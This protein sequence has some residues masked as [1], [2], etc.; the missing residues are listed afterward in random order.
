MV[1]GHRA[2]IGYTSP[3]AATEVFPYEF[4]LAAPEGVTLV[5]TTL[6]IVE[7]SPQEVDRSYEISVRAAKEMAR[8]G[9]DLIVF[10]G[11][12]INV[13]RGFENVDALIRETEAEVGVPV[14]TSLNSQMAGLRQVGARRVAVVHP[15]DENDL[16][17]QRLFKGRLEGAGFEYVGCVGAGYRAIDLGKIPLETALE[18]GRQ[19]V[20]DHPE[21]DTILVSCPHWAVAK[22]IDAMERELERPVVTSSQSIIWN[23]L[24]LCGIDDRVDGYGR[25]LREY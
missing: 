21:A 25:L 10:G 7:L 1:Y 11:V 17:P 6:A 19:V 3:P 15:F 23:A 5:L 20:R 4:Y 12:P 18:L 9:A 16:G 14:T 13:S 24:R 22:S 8:A 2:R